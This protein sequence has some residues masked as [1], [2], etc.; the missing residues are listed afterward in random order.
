MARDP[1]VGI[2]IVICMPEL[3]DLSQSPLYPFS[4]PV[5]VSQAS[6]SN[7]SG[8]FLSNEPIITDLPPSNCW[9]VI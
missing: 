6:S 4:L 7:L 2:C 3:L 9:G 1:W 5:N 8:Q